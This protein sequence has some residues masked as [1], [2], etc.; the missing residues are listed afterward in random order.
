[1]GQMTPAQARVVD[2]VLTAVAQGIKQQDLI[3]SA[4]FPR[5]NVPLRA[6]KI[7]V[8]GREDFMLYA[9][10]RAPGENTRRVSF[11]RGSTPYALE[12]HALEAT[13]D[14]STRDEAQNSIG[15]DEQERYL[16]M[17]RR[18]IA[19]RTEK[20]QA[21]LARTA[22]NYQASNK[23]SLTGTARWSDFSGTSDPLVDVEAG[24][25]AI[26]AKIGLYPNTIVI[27]A[28]VWK[29]LKYHP[30]LIDRIK[31]TSRD[32]LSVEMVAE[33]LEV[34]NIVI[35]KSVYSTDAGV[36]A[37][38]WGKD[39]ILAYTDPASME[40]MGAPTYGYTYGLDGF[41]QVEEPYIDRA[42]KSMV[43]PVTDEL[44][45]VMTAPDAGYLIQTAVA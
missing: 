40:A 13:I 17:T 3:G 43:M 10:A 26:R 1:M 18:I 42:T 4:L 7:I 16:A 35:G 25:E 14:L 30:K 21:D 27:P 20:A 9:T 31:Y 8:F 2:P 38:V 37:D 39:V 34:E 5:V 32:S 41:P 28:A 45:P 12:Q 44:Q 29:S 19:L 11:G 24:K 23:T 36:L 22:A 6:G 15:I 33:L